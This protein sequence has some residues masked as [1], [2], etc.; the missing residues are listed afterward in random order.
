[1]SAWINKARELSEQVDTVIGAAVPASNDPSNITY[2]DTATITAVQNKLKALGYFNGKVDG[3]FGPI[4]DAAILSYSGQ[5]G[6][7]NT[8]LLTK[9][10]LVSDISFSDD[11]ADSMVVETSQANTPAQVQ[12]VA[13][14]VENLAADAPPD[15]QAQVNDAKQ[16]AATATTPAEVEVAKDK[17]QQAIKK[18]RQSKAGFLSINVP[19]INRPLWQVGAGVLGLSV[20]S[21]GVYI[22]FRNRGGYTS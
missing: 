10:G 15:V 8:A 20:V 18:V 2:T 14:K 19:G 12:I 6:P 21:F 9:L 11:E 5:H 4:T 7:P 3:K 16:A 1:M 13:A 22:I 17:V